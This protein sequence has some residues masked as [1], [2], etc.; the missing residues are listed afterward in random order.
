M[1]YSALVSLAFATAAAA[2]P[3][4][5]NVTGTSITPS[6]SNPTSK[7]SLA[8][9]S[10]PSS[11]RNSSIGTASGFTLSSASVCAPRGILQVP[12]RLHLAH[13]RQGLEMGVSIRAGLLEQVTAILHP[14]LLSHNHLQQRP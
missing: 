8:T 13:H 5:L 14:L 4:H 10:A 3:Q 7:S 2:W 12:V 1:Q 11:I 6:A 9:G